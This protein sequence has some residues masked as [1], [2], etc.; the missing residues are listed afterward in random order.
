MIGVIEILKSHNLTNVSIALMIIINQLKN[1][2]KENFI[3]KLRND[4]PTYNE[5]ERMTKIIELFIITIGEELKNST[6]KMTL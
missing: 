6:W 1:R 5:I 4:Y 2:K 3:K